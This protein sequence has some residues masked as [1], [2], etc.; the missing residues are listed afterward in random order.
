M[1]LTEKKQITPPAKP[2]IIEESGLTKP[3]PGVMAT[4]P[5]TQ[6]LTAPRTVGLPLYSHSANTQE[7]VAAAAEACVVT[8]ALAANPLAPKALPALKPNQP[9]QRREPPIRTIGRL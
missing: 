5:A 3:A 6:P 4:R 9:N 2:I 8:K 1:T 7:T